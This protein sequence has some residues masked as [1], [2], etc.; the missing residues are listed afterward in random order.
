MNVYIT[1][2]F[3]CVYVCMCVVL[4]TGGYFPFLADCTTNPQCRPLF[5]ITK[6]PSGVA[7]FRPAFVLGSA[8]FVAT[9]K[10][11]QMQLR[12]WNIFISPKI[13]EFIENPTQQTYECT[14][15]I[16]WSKNTRR[17]YCKRLWENI[18]TWLRMKGMPDDSI[19]NHTTPYT[20][21]IRYWRI[22]EELRNNVVRFT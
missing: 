16:G 15:M 14:N 18:V 5:Q 8:T 22:R 12:V 9:A 21:I 7:K 19:T 6:V 4:L 11:S 10:C 20:N 1:W 13:R 17:H 2:M 3:C